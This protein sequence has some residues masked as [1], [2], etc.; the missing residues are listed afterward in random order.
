[1]NGKNMKTERYFQ[2]YGAIPKLGKYEVVK[3]S[4]LDNIVPTECRIFDTFEQADKAA[5]FMHAQNSDKLGYI[6][7]R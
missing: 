7:M 3:I 2:F 5:K 4:R 1:M 6:N